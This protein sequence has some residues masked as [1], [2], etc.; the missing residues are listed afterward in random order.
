[1]GTPLVL[2]PERCLGRAYDSK[3]DLWALGCVVY[4]LLTLRPAFSASCLN[5]LVVKIVQ[6]ACTRSRS[7]GSCQ[8]I[9]IL[10]IYV[11]NQNA[12]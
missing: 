5:G 6:G 4:E 11:Y 7:C 10:I 8:A 9:I 2:S 1:M 3:S 12:I